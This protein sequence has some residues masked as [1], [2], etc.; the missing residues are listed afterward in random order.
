MEQNEP[1]K[2]ATGR[3]RRVVELTVPSDGADHF[4][5]PFDS[6]GESLASDADPLEFS[7]LL[8]QLFAELFGMD[9]AAL[10]T[11]SA[12]GALRL[13]VATGEAVKQVD[14]FQVTSREGPCPECCRSGQIIAV[15]DLA[16]VTDRWP[17]LCAVAAVAG[18]RSAYAVPI[19]RSGRTV[20]SIDLFSARPRGLLPSD[21]RAAQGFADL[22]S[23][24]ISQVHAAHEAHLLES[25]LRRALISRV[26]IEQAK[27]VLAERYQIDMQG[28]FARLRSYARSHNRRLSDV[29]VE[30]LHHALDI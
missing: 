4:D 26:V 24:S 5:S 7:T 1:V 20:G 28:A 23:I 19:R 29:A 11:K 10:V 12:S 9:D 22:A 8:I 6:L 2:P 25:Q 27:G 18:F 15:A 21:L 13:L 16:T 30:L 14:L 17:R 3:S